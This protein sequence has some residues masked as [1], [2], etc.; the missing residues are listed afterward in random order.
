MII[1]NPKVLVGADS[2]SWGEEVAAWYARKRLKFKILGQNVRVRRRDEIDL[3]CRDR[4]ILVFLEVKTRKNEAFGAP[5]DA[6]DASKR[7]HLS[8]AAVRYI[9]QLKDPRILVRFDVIEVVGEPSRERIEVR[10][11]PDVFQ[12]EGGYEFPGV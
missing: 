4:K 1:S 6:V 8:R 9:S 11:L 10:Y 3:I 12:I 7:A 5:I 2:G